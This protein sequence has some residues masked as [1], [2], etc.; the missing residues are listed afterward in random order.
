[1]CNNPLQ[2]TLHV[3]RYCFQVAFP[4]NVT[5]LHNNKKRQ[6]YFIVNRFLLCYKRILK[7]VECILM[8][9]LLLGM[10]YTFLHVP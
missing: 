5:S 2:E 6:N 10:Q 9:S 4:Y 8:H 7:A 3:I 1:M